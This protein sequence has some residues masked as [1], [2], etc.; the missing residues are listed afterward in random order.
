MS[1]K[2]CWRLK[3]NHLNLESIQAPLEA[4]IPFFSPAIATGTLRVLFGLES[5]Q[6]FNTV[7]VVNLNADLLRL[8]RLLILLTQRSKL[9]AEKLVLWNLT[10]ELFTSF[11]DQVIKLSHWI[12]L[13]RILI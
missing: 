8:L 2:T 3:R 12:E 6:V 13:I 7:L 5:D 10:L 9:E 11:I 4:M 1:K